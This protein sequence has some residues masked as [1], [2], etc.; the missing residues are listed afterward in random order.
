MLAVAESSQI[1]GAHDAGAVAL[2]KHRG[3]ENGRSEL[4]ARLLLAVQTTVVSFRVG[5]GALEGRPRTLRS[6]NS[7][8]VDPTIKANLHLGRALHR[9]FRPLRENFRRSRLPPPRRLHKFR[10]TP[11]VPLGQISRPQGFCHPYP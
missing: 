5:G 10:I 3:K 6:A 7:F 1:S 4:S 2:V 9:D 8:K 11:N